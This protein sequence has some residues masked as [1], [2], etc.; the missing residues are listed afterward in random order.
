MQELAEASFLSKKDFFKSLEQSTCLKP[1]VV[2]SLG[3]Y[4]KS[5]GSPVNTVT[6]RL[7]LEWPLKKGKPLDTKYLSSSFEMAVAASEIYRVKNYLESRMGEDINVLDIRTGCINV[8]FSLPDDVDVSMVKQAVT[9]LS[10]NKD[11]YGVLC[12]DGNV[13]GR[14]ITP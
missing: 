6:V 12:V 2:Y 13:S 9:S 10:N 14:S 5:D 1:G 4:F 3:K 7:A 11:I 8:R